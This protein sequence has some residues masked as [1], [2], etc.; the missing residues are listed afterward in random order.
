MGTLFYFAKDEEQSLCHLG[1]KGI[2]SYLQDLLEIYNKTKK[3]FEKSYDIHFCKI[4]EIEDVIEFIDTYWQKSH[5]LTKSKEL[6]DWQHY[7]K[8]NNRYNFVIARFKKDNQIHGI[9]GFILSSIY[10]ASIETPIR[11][12]AIWKVRDDVAVKGLGLALKGYMEEHIPVEYIGG[13]GLSE[14]S[15]TIDTKLGEKMGK[16]TQYYIA[17]PDCQEYELI[18]NPKFPNLDNITIDC[19]INF[20]KINEDEFDMAIRELSGYLMPYKSAEYY[21]NRYY[22]HPIYKYYFVTVQKDT[23][24]EAIFVYRK[25]SANNRNCIFIVDYIGDENGLMGAYNEFLR[26]LKEE[27]A[28]HISFPCSGLNNEKMSSVG[29]FTREGSETILP[30]YF[31][32]FVRKNVDLDY[33]FWTSENFNSELIVKGDADQD[34]PNVIPEI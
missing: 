11:W 27:N 19:K 26:L 30:V 1:K 31:E 33:H 13:V 10:D 4:N 18:C 2:G 21:K 20:Q 3:I 29:F 6:L 5:I 24:K 16:L 34:R 12:G 22:R 7:D 32:P 9:I 25:C 8:I 28:E 14:Y 23:K 17:N 15:K